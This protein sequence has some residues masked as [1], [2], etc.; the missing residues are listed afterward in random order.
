MDARV[1]ESERAER[2]AVSLERNLFAEAHLGSKETDRK[3]IHNKNR[4]MRLMGAT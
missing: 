1:A 2:P 3:P 4:G